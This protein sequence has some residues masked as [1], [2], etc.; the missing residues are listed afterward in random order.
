MLLQKSSRVTT[1]NHA[2]FG[3]SASSSSFSSAVTHPSKVTTTRRFSEMCWSSPWHLILPTGTRSQIQQKTWSVRCL[4]RIPPAESRLRRACS[5]HGSPRTISQITMLDTILNFWNRIS[6]WF[7][8]E[9]RIS[10]SLNNFKLPLSNSWSIRLTRVRLISPN[11]VMHS[12]RL[13]RTIRALWS[14]AN[15]GPPSMSSTCQ[16]MR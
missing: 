1:T 13:T 12:G 4:R 11:C 2:T 9:L 10:V 5:T 14:S 8:A 3:L 7:C 6:L 15:S 16:K